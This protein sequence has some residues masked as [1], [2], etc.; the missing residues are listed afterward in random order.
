MYNIVINI[1]SRV[2]TKSNYSAKSVFLLLQK[3]Y[4][5]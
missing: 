4:F 2:I 5:Q 3:Y 1:K